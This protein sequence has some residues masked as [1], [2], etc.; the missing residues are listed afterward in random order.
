[1]PTY[2]YICKECS[3][4]YDVFHK[5]REIEEDVVCPSCGSA[6]HRKVMSVTMM[7]MGGDSYSSSYDSSSSSSCE[8]GSCCGGSCGVN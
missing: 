5:V 6:E 4:K 2:E 8:S 7:S 1:M 3:A